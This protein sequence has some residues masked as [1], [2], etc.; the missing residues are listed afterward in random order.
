MA[1]KNW[2]LMFPPHLTNAPCIQLRRD[3]QR[4]VGQALGQI[5]S[6]WAGER[7]GKY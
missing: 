5:L 7:E 1:W 3:D 2:G 6:H 4:R